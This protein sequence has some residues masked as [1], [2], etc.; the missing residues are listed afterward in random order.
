MPSTGSKIPSVPILAN[1]KKSHDVWIQRESKSLTPQ[2]VGLPV[3]KA[4]MR[5]WSEE[6]E[7]KRKMLETGDTGPI[8]EMCEE[9]KQSKMEVYGGV[10]EEYQEMVI[11]FG[12]VT[13]FAAAFPLTAALALLNNLIEIRTDAY[14]LLHATQRPQ[15]KSCADIGT[16]GYILDIITTV[17]ILTNCALV[18]FTSHGLFFYLPDLNSVER[19]WATIMFEHALLVFKIILEMLLNEPPSEAV[20][21]YER[22]C[23]LRDKVLAECEFLEPEEGEA[24]FYTDDEEEDEY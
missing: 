15:Y 23:F 21:A 4:K 19:V 20:A 3:F 8:I 22:R 11:Q 1:L 18:G 9:E 16:W 5:A 2:Q 14:K 24:A 13:L 12:Y 17:S 10:F 6:K 7:M